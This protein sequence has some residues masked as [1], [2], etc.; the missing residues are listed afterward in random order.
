MFD[1]DEPDLNWIELFRTN[2]YVGL[3]R[4]SDANQVSFGLTTQVYSSAS[5]LR[6]LS[7]TIG[8]RFNFKSPRV[9]LPDEARTPAMP[10]T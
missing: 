4:I 8:Q 7:T 1:T 9:R 6:L 3:D 5:G 2:R 10:P